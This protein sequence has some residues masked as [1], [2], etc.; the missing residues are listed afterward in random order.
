MFCLRLIAHEAKLVRL[1]GAGFG[2]EVCLTLVGFWTIKTDLVA[3][4]LAVCG[5]YRRVLVKL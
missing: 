3:V 1:F 4:S 2:T 5:V